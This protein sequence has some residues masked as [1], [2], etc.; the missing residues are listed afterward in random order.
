[1]FLDILNSEPKYIFELFLSDTQRRAELSPSSQSNTC[2][3]THIPPL[4]QKPRKV[5]HTH[6]EI[7][8]KEINDL[9]T[10]TEILTSRIFT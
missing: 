3:R 5:T 10:K 6:Q 4:T 7:S 9:Y 2:T 1:M 8:L